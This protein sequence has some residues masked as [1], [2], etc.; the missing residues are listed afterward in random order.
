MITIAEIA[1]KFKTSRV[2][3]SNAL[4]H[5]SGV[6]PQLA[7]RIRDY[8]HEIGYVPNYMAKALISGR[9]AIIG[10][11]L[12]EPPS[13]PWFG[14]LL[15]NIQLKLEN[16]GYYPNTVILE[17]GLAGQAAFPRVT[18]ALNFFRQ[19]QAEAVLLGPCD[20][21]SYDY[22]VSNAGPLPNIIYFDAL[23]PLPAPTLRLD[24]SA[25]MEMVMGHLYKLG[26]REIGYV[27]LNECDESSPSPNTRF[28]V[29]RRFL[30]AHGCP[31]NPDWH[32]RTDTIMPNLEMLE[33]I[34]ALLRSPH[35][36]TALF[37]HDDNYGFMTLRA[38][39][40]TNIRIPEELSVIGF[41]NLPISLYSSP[42]LTSVGFN[43]KTYVLKLMQLLKATL[44]GKA[45]DE[46]NWLV[47]PPMLI[48]RESTA[49]PCR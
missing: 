38:A 45:K 26:H 42:G 35:R 6:A 28:A 10:I 20:R 8:A 21:Q 29:F 44:D 40:E 16:D 17:A 7:Q 43:Q 30:E 24:F 2:T 11:C 37:C 25:G 32:V 34:K 31:V 4:N 36:P 46:D 15:S 23:D 9:T 3:V 22:I 39:L 48:K 49:R 33:R 41:D 1:L 47:E 19:I 18:R 13:D 14:E 27:G 5:R 12:C